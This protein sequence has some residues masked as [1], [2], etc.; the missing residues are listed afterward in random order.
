MTMKLDL[1]AADRVAVTVGSDTPGIDAQLVPTEPTPD[2]TPPDTEIESGPSG[3]IATNEATFAARGVP[4]VDSARIQCRIDDEAFADCGS[5][6]TFTGLADGSHTVSFRAE[7]AAG[8]QDATP[9]TQ[10]FTVDTA[11]YPPVS[12]G[13][14]KITRSPS[15]ARRRSRRQEGHL[16]GQDLQLRQYRGNRSEAQGQRQGPQL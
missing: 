6:R 16:Q 12:P 7:D 9:A 1:A 4:A 3:K 2:V 15:R 11:V 5:P 14:A 10:S 13:E 8:N